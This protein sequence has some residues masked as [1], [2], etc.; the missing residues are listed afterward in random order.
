[1]NKQSG[2]IVTFEPER[3]DLCPVEQADS[4]PFFF[5]SEHG[6]FLTSFSTCGPSVLLAVPQ[7]LY[8]GSSFTLFPPGLLSACLGA[9]ICNISPNLRNSALNNWSI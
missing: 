9:H 7:A 2:Q 4:Q 6:L 5:L 3:S 8:Y 1:M